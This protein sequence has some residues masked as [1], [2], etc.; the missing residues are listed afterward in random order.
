MRVARATWLSNPNPN[1]NPDPNLTLTQGPFGH[2]CGAC[3]LVGSE[4]VVPLHD[5]APILLLVVGL[6]VP[7]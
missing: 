7:G 2:A 5:H 3:E 4:E 6:R 1:P